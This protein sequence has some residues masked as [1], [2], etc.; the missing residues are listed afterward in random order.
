M[1]S[2][3]IINDLQ[4]KL[5][6][7]LAQLNCDHENEIITDSTNIEHI[8]CKKCCLIDSPAQ[9]AMDA[10]AAVAADSQPVL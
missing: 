9:W 3:T 10:V 6:I 5:A 8:R 7:T 2:D 1:I 4:S